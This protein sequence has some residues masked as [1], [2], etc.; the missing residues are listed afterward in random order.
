MRG[1]NDLLSIYLKGIEPLFMFMIGGESKVG[2][3]P[4]CRQIEHRRKSA[5]LIERFTPNLLGFDTPL[6]RRSKPAVH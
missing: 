4:R 6:R 1:G 3:R 2:L 5:K